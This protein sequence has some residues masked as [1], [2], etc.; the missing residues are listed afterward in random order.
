MI[1][2]SPRS[3]GTTSP[4]LELRANPRTP[5]AAVAFIQPLH[6]GAT[7][8]FRVDLIDF[9]PQGGGGVGL[10]TA[11]PLPR[12]APVVLSIAH[13]PPMEGLFLCRVAHCTNLGNG[14][15]HIGLTI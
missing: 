6:A 1:S 7:P 13:H 10:R 9:H 11:I 12:A 8:T 3:P 5:D 2:N 15:Y 14:R 4:P